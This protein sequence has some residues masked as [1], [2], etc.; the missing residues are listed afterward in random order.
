MKMNDD[1]IYEALPKVRKDFAESLYA[2]ISTQAPIAKRQKWS[3]RLRNL[4]WSQVA[5]IVLIVLLLVAWSQIRLWIRYVP[6][7]DLWLVEFSLTQPASDIQTV[8]TIP[9]PGQLPT[10]IINDGTQSIIVSELRIVYLSPDWIPEGFS[11]TR[12][13][14]PGYS[15]EESIGMWSNK[16]GETIRLFV[17]PPEGGARPYAP[18][19]MYKE[20][21]I[22]GQPAILVYGRLAPNSAENPQ[23]QRKWDETLGLQLTWSVEDSIYTLETLGS[24]VTEDD[25]LRMAE[26]LKVVPPPEP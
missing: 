19:G 3:P 16:A 7:G 8:E 23:A 14:G 22:K 1:F 25:L 13:P 9:T 20:V 2:K 15:Y 6:I 11:A 17:V 5:M 24:Y 26:S 18:P 12:I 21:Q 10:V 4:R